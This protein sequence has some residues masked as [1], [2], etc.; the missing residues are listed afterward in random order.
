MMANICGLEISH[1]FE[2]TDKITKGGN[3]KAPIYAGI[4]QL[5]ERRTRNA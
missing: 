4:A 1:G 3:L 2:N 5:V